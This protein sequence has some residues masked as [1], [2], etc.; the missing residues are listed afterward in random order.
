MDQASCN[1]HRRSFS[2]D[3]PLTLHTFHSVL[4]FAK[5]AVSPEYRAYL[6]AHG[7]EAEVV[8][9]MRDMHSE[10]IMAI[11][12][13]AALVVLTCDSPEHAVQVSVPCNGRTCAVPFNAG[14]AS[15]TLSRSCT[16][17]CH[18]HLARLPSCHPRLRCSVRR[19][20]PRYWWRCCSISSVPRARR[21]LRGPT[22]RWPSARFL[23]DLYLWFSPVCFQA[24]M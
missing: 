7:T 6:R 5:K 15:F 16:L 24:S 9:L 13:A 10:P 21:A 2:F 1:A 18:P 3:A 22:R 14:R 12:A 4:K 20:I 17:C 11:T 23:L 8:G 19:A